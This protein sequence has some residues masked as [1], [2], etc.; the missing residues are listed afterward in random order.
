MKRMLLPM[1]LL[2]SAAIAGPQALPDSELAQVS[3]ADGISFAVKL[4]LNRQPDAGST[5]SRLTIAQTVDAR[6]T[7]MVVRNIGGV[8]TMVGLNISPQTAADGTGTNYVAL[9]LPGY[10]RFTDT[11]FD[12]ISVQAD[13]HGPVSGNLGRVSLNGEMTMQG[14]LRLW[15]H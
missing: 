13:P 12:S 11:G 5:D 1:L 9:T 6:T 14:Q 8:I 10:A 2:C 15:S 4:N 3:G 7:Y